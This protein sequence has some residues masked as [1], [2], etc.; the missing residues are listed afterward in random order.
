MSSKPFVAQRELLYARLGATDK[1]PFTVRIGAPYFLE[2]ATTPFD[3]DSG[4]AGC[5]ITFDGLNVADIEVH[6]IDQV[7]ALSLAVD[8][9]RVL[10]GLTKE[11]L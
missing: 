10:R 1:H 7:H 6:G 5:T 11:R 9:D 3:F 2:K 8:V 4:A